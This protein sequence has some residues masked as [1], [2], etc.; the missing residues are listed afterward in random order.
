MVIWRVLAQLAIDFVFD[1]ALHAGVTAAEKGVADLHPVHG[2]HQS[3]ARPVRV[4]YAMALQTPGHGT[5]QGEDGSRVLPLEGVAHRVFAE[6]ADPLREDSLPAFGFQLVPVGDL[7]RRP[8]KDGVPN[9][10]P[11]V[12]GKLPPF[13]QGGH[14]PRPIE[15]LVP[16]GFEPVSL[17]GRGSLLFFLLL[18]F[19][20]V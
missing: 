2:R 18:G 12:R 10:F 16:I 7:H 13:G 19:P 14:L 3:S 9:L 20:V 17:Q 4:Q 6:R 8:E 1:L 15:D 11:R 5:T